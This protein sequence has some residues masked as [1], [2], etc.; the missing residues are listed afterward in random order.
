MEIHIPADFTLD[1][2][3]A[4][5]EGERQEAVEGHYTAKEWADHFG[6]HIKKMRRILKRAKEQG[7][8]HMVRVDRLALDDKI[9]S[10]PAYALIKAQNE[11]EKT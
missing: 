9:H 3:Q 5:I 2:L 8:L 6:I 1:E 10:V 4:F 11:E 7:F